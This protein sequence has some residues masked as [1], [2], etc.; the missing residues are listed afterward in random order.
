[1]ENLV[2]Q[3]ISATTAICIPLTVLT[4]Y[5]S[6]TMLLTKKYQAAGAAPLKNAG[7]ELIE[8]SYDDEA[9][10]HRLNECSQETNCVEADVKVHRRL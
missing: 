1:M 4:K 6:G 10:F 5:G 2:L 8:P 3:T 7:I 9:I